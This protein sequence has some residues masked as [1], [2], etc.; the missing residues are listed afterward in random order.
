MKTYHL[1]KGLQSDREKL[2]PTQAKVD[3]PPIQLNPRMYQMPWGKYR[4]QTIYT[5]PDDYL[6]LLEDGFSSVKFG[7]PPDSQ[8]FKV[9]GY[10]M[11]M[12][13]T[14]LKGR[15]YRKRGSRWER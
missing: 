12:A 7:K 15:G 6:M 11:E 5:L 8:R 2:T 14:V 1:H 4:N 10:L 13:R 9:P 3:R